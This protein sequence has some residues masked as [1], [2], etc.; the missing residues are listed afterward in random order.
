MGFVRGYTAFDSVSVNNYT[1]N[2]FQFLLV[3]TSKEL[4]YL[5]ADGVCGI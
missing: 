2:G 1:I 3:K 4:G 5:Q